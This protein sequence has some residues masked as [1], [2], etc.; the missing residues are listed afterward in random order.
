MLA[1][2]FA[3]LAAVCL[4][5]AVGIA[6]LVP[7]GLTLEQGVLLYDKTALDW[8][9]SH[10]GTWLWAWIETPF[11]ARPLWLLPT[12]LGVVFAGLATSFNL[13]TA[14]PSRRRRS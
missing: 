1:R 4:V 8:A 11:L 5:L 2:V 3:I 7:L 10:S 12:C 14:S 9:R 6:S 13:G